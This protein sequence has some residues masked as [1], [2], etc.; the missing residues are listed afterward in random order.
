MNNN[1]LNYNDRRLLFNL[2]KMFLKLSINFL[3]LFINLIIFK[4]VS[5]YECSE[6]TMYNLSNW[7]IFFDNKN[8][9]DAIDNYNMALLYSCDYS[10]ILFSINYNIALS[11]WNLNKNRDAVI[12]FDKSLRYTNDEKEIKKINDYIDYYSALAKDDELKWT[13]ATNDPYSYKQYY[14]RS[15]SIVPAWNKVDNPKEVIVAVIDDWVWLN[16]PDLKKNIIWNV[17]DFTWDWLKNYAEWSHW[18]MVSWIIWAEINNNIWISWIAK[19]VKIMPLRVFWSWTIASEDNV[20]TA[21]NYAVDNNANIINISLGESQ[22]YWTTKFDKAIKYAYDNWVIVVNSAWNWDLLSWN[23]IWLDTTTNPIYP[24]CNNWWKSEYSFWVWS[25]KQDWTKSDWSNYWQCVSFWLPWEN[26]TSISIPSYTNNYWYD[27]SDWT[28][29]SAPILS[30]IIALWYNK[31]WYVP[32]DIIKSELEKSI[33]DFSWEAITWTNNIIKIINTDKYLTNLWLRID[34]IISAQ[35]KLE[36]SRILKKEIIIEKDSS[37]SNSVIKSDINENEE[38]N[39]NIT[40]NWDY[41]ASKW[42]VKKQELE[43]LY[44]L[45]DYLLRQEVIW[46]AIKLWWITLPEDYECKWYYSDVSYNTPNTWACRAVEISADN[47]IITRSNN[48]FRPE[49]RI[50]K[51]EALAIILKWANIDISQSTSSFF[52]DVNI[53]WQTNIVN[54]AINNQVIDK[55]TYFFP[56]QFATRWEIFEMAK[57]ILVNKK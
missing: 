24:V 47:S 13:S 39:L 18:T 37:E 22:F 34:E 2:L 42:I 27:T 1:I 50:T 40:N 46:M 44:R 9:F 53:Q 55:W 12:Y 48:L 15:L 33:S 4:S 35:N 16:A 31:Y 49:D 19:N 14:L 52:S 26:I 54:S 56:N 17:I 43:E 29:F 30:W 51:A 21:I 10:E 11:Y 32:F 7:N 57:R 36:Q 38:N 28:S 41:L 8:Y 20:V 6:K 23:Q 5:A 3:L 45:D 25:L